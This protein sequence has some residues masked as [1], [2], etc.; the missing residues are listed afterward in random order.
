[1][2]DPSVLDKFIDMFVTTLPKC[3]FCKWCAEDGYTCKAFPDGIPND[4]L[5]DPKENEC[6]NGI[7]F[8]PEDE[9]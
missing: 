2:S 8:E 9:E 1:M 7:F 6:N 5:G 3:D 4:V